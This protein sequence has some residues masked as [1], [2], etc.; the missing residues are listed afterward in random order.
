[1]TCARKNDS[2]S[3]LLHSLLVKPHSRT[4]DT[5]HPC[6][7]SLFWIVRQTV[8][9]QIDQRSIAL[10]LRRVAHATCLALTHALCKARE[11]GRRLTVQR[12]TT[13]DSDIFTV[14]PWNRTF[15]NLDHTKTNMVTPAKKHGLTV[16]KGDH[17]SSVRSSI[18]SHSTHAPRAEHNR[19]PKYHSCTTLCRRKEGYS[20]LRL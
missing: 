15:E 8:G 9:K 11:L 19:A 2:R 17:I 20:H 16:Q 3:Q 1:M 12:H 13:H 5:T 14:A 6:R 7:W 4:Q 18:H 10:T